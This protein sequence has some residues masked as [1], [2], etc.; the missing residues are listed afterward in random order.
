MQV[1]AIMMLWA[2]ASLM[3]A[4]VEAAITAACG[5]D[6][7]EPNNERGKAKSTRG[8]QISA[9][10]CRGDADWYYVTPEPG[11]TLE[12]V[13]EHDAA[14]PVTVDLF[15]PRSRAAAGETSTEGGRTVVRFPVTAKAKHR[16]RIQ[17]AD[18][19]TVAYTLDVRTAPR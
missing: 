5:A 7:Y 8:K 11:R 9:R 12:V 19:S 1:L 13:V 16:L 17:S 3:P 4:T 15:P 2:T 10:V 18:G 14:H 6:S